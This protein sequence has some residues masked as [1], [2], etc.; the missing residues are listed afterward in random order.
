MSK[1]RPTLEEQLQSLQ[2]GFFGRDRELKEAD[3]IAPTPCWSLSNEF[4]PTIV[5]PARTQRG[6]RPYQA[7][8]IEPRL[9]G[10][11]SHHT[12]TR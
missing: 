9:H 3:S 11:P 5:T 4:A 6:L 8:D 12:T 10:I 7:I 1:Q 2:Q